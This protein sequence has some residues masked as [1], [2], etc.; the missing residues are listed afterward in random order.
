[1]VQDPLNPDLDIVEAIDE[2][3]RYATLWA[4]FLPA[5]G[6]RLRPGNG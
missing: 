1:M 5:L 4:K 2:S 6:S 3:P